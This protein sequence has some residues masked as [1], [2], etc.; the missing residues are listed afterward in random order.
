MLKLFVKLDDPVGDGKRPFDAIERILLTTS[1]NLQRTVSAMYQRPVKVELIENKR[2]IAD[3]DV[4]M[5]QVQLHLEQ[6][7]NDQDIPFGVAVS[8]LEL[9]NHDYAQ[10]F[11]DNQPG[12]G[13]FFAHFNILP[14]FEL[15]TADRNFDQETLI[16][17]DDMDSQFQKLFGSVDIDDRVLR[18]IKDNPENIYRIYK[19][20]Y[21]DF[22]CTLLEVLSSSLLSQRAI[23]NTNVIQSQ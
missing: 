21:R 12:L 16:K 20:S 18:F 7:L 17:S 9:F 6:G 3:R 19:L 23:L 4:Y 10:F 13:Q 5:R 14:A 8:K 11:S 15:I 22:D 1:G 2:L